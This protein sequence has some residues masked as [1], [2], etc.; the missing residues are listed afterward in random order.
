[1]TTAATRLKD[2]IC[3]ITGGAS[4]IGLA[5][6]RRLTE[7]GAKVVIG[8]LD[9]VRGPEV[10]E[11]LGGH[12]ERVNVADEEEVKNLFA[13]TVEHF[14]RV[15]VAFNNAGINPTDDNSILTTDIE[16]W[17]RVQ[18]VNLTSVYLCSKYALEHM[19]KQGSGV[20]HQYGVIRRA[21]GSGDFADLLLGVERRSP[22]DE[23]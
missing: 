13:R 12:F 17:A 9:E 2:K 16:A 1:M 22:V 21:H 18:T 4:G 20:G 15:D 14:G 6:A 8:D 7:E 23:P 10:A 19:V 11:E 5:S 3:V